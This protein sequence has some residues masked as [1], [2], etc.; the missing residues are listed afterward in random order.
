MDKIFL[1][2]ARKAGIAL[3]CRLA[4]V[5]TLATFSTHCV[6]SSSSSSYANN[7]EKRQL[8]VC[9]QQHLPNKIHGTNTY[10]LLVREKALRIRII[11][12]LVF[13]LGLAQRLHQ[14][15]VL[16]ALQIFRINWLKRGLLLLLFFR[17]AVQESEVA[18]GSF[19]DCAVL[20]ESLISEGQQVLKRLQR[21]FAHAV[22]VV[23][24]VVLDHVLSVQLHILELLERLPVVLVDIMSA[25]RHLLKPHRLVI[26]NADIVAAVFDEDVHDAGAEF[27]LS[28][29]ESEHR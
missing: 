9:R 25:S 29:L 1:P 14:F 20:L 23:V 3:A 21:E 8:C 24:V 12:V 2:L 27:N 6:R 15:G 28:V 17:D 10:Q 13:V 18:D 4:S 11:F 22:L 5:F 19:D 7:H 16:L 26:V